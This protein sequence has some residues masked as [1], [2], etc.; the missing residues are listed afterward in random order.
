MLLSWSDGK[1]RY[2]SGREVGAFATNV[3]HAESETKGETG[4]PAWKTVLQRR[5]GLAVQHRANQM[6]AGVAKG[7]QLRAGLGGIG[8]S[9]ARQPNE[10]GKIFPQQDRFRNGRRREFDEDHDII[11]GAPMF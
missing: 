3:R 5:H 7:F 6:A 1:R 10:V 9:A 2:D 11:Y 4:Q 8:Q